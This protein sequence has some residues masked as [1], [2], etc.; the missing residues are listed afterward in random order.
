MEVFPPDEL[1][2]KIPW[3]FFSFWLG[4]KNNLGVF[5]PIHMA[6]KLH[7]GFSAS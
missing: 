6:E 2:E 3:I 7:G 1:A 5:P 4:R